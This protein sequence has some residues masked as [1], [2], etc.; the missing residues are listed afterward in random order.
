MLPEL[1]ACTYFTYCQTQQD[2]KG[3]LHLF[4]DAIYAKV[5]K[6]SIGWVRSRISSPCGAWFESGDGKDCALQRAG[7]AGWA[8]LQ[9]QPTGK[10]NLKDG[11][12]RTHRACIMVTPHPG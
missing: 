7:L 12:I 5:N 2:P 3:A 11:T 1:R 4:Y 10:V 6:Q 9:K 8:R